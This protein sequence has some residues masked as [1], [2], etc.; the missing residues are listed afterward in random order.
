MNIA[1]W[2]IVAVVGVSAIISLVRGFVREALSLLA[3]GAAF[4]AATMFHGSVAHWLEGVMATPSLRFIAAWLGV[5]L[6]VLLGLGLINFVISRLIRASGLSG[7]DR[8]LGSL[9][10]VARGLIVVLTALIVVPNFLPLKQDAWWRES[11][12]I[13]YFL[14]FEGRAREVAGTL[15]DWF[16]QLIR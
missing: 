16:Q 6:A 9:F 11:S 13:P 1:D 5:F 10:G 3:W 15:V 8:F 7:T 12:L 2:M 4:A 14:G